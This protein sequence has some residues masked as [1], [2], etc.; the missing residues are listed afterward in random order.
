MYNYLFVSILFISCSFKE[1]PKNKASQE[2]AQSP[3]EVLGKEDAIKIDIIVSRPEIID[4]FNEFS[5]HEVQ[6][7]YN[8]FKKLVKIE[9]YKLY[10]HFKTDSTYVDTAKNYLFNQLVHSFFPSWNKTTWDFNGYSAIPRKGEIACG[11]FVS[12]NLL[13]V[14]FNID[15]YELAKKYSHDVAYIMSDTTKTYFELEPFIND[16]KEKEDNIYIV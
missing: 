12:T 7:N 3:K 8:K 16:V 14:G 1:S 6:Q 10:K 5:N 13:H 2:H 15:R 11:Y 4:P 9:K